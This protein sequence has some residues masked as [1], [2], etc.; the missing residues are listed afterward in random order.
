MMFGE[1][2][3]VTKIHSLIPG[4]VPAPHGWGKY[5]TGSPDTYFFLS[6]FL[7]MD[8][9]APDPAQF[10]ARLA[11]LHHKGT[12][13]NGKFGFEVTTCDGKLPHVTEWE[14]S[15]ATFYGKLLRGVLNLDAEVNGVWPEL[16]AAAAQVISGVIPRLLGVLQSEGRSIKPSLIHGDCWEGNIG[17]LLETGDVVFYDAGSYYA[18][19]E[20]E[21]GIWRGQQGQSFR[22]QVYP[23]SYLRNFEAAEPKDEWDDR[24]RLYSMKYNLNYSGGHPGN[25]TRQT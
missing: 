23:R 11:E 21:L 17:T 1:F 20:M 15:W 22:A 6:D 10:T 2:T 14:S 24:N 16:E 18:H 4:L 13:P 9:A 19:N 5:K 7:D 3:S 12:S 25:I 8:T